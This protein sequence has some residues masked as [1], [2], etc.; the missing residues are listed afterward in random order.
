MRLIPTNYASLFKETIEASEIKLGY[1]IIEK[2]GMNEEFSEF[3][4]EHHDEPL[5]D[6]MKA[7]A[8]LHP[9]I[10]YV[11]DEKYFKKYEPM[12]IQ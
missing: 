12:L 1:E 11:P 3:L 9:D 6:V 2:A 7:F 5:S 8:K 10:F 4:L